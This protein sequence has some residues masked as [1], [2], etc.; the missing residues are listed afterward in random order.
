MS[1]NRT[2]QTTNKNEVGINLTVN[3]AGLGRRCGAEFPENLQGSVLCESRVSISV[4]M[5]LVALFLCAC[6]A[7]SLGGD[8]PF[9]AVASQRAAVGLGKAGVETA[10]AADKSRALNQGSNVRTHQENVDI[11]KA[12]VNKEYSGNSKKSA[13][14][15]QA[16][17]QDWRQTAGDHKSQE[18]AGRRSQAHAASHAADQSAKQRHNANQFVDKN[19]NWAGK[20]GFRK[21]N[22]R[23]EGIS[24]AFDKNF[25]R[26]ANENG[27]FNA[28]SNLADHALD[29]VAVRSTQYGRWVGDHGAGA[30]NADRQSADRNAGWNNA[31]WANRAA[32]DKF[33][34]DADQAAGANGN[35]KD[36]AEKRDSAVNRDIYHENRGGRAFDYLN[37][38]ALLDRNADRKSAGYGAAA[39]V[40]KGYAPAYGYGGPYGYGVAG[41][42]LNRQVY[43]HLPFRRI[44]YGDGYGVAGKGLNRQRGA[45]DRSNVWDAAQLAKNQRWAADGEVDRLKDAALANQWQQD[46]VR[47][48]N[49][50]ERAA[51]RDVGFSRDAAARNEGARA[52]NDQAANARAAHTAGQ[53]RHDLDENANLEANKK[54]RQSDR[55]HK[56]NEYKKF[57]NNDQKGGNNFERLKYNRGT[58]EDAAAADFDVNRDDSS[59][60]RDAHRLDTA[61]AAARS[62]DGARAQSAHRNH[63]AADGNSNRAGAEQQAAS[64][65][66]AGN[67]GWW[68]AEGDRKKYAVE[69]LRRDNNAKNAVA[70]NQ[71]SARAGFDNRAFGK[72]RGAFVGSAAAVYPSYGN[73]GYGYPAAGYG[74]YGNFPQYGGNYGNYGYGYP[75]SGKYGYY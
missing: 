2:A 67:R 20:Q 4:I 41:K 19:Q 17:Q 44:L 70:Q 53:A 64:A 3:S 28:G 51:M 73:Y 49:T 27:G 9:G 52:N 63:H 14:D 43:V 57:F 24:Y 58:T 35:A 39:D 16:H 26:N 29:D 68:G 7:G 6:I 25:R 22:R 33:G 34:R 72:N 45:A 75:A 5:K 11:K 74:G 38:R 31:A 55:D 15:Q 10:K 66:E 21:G 40:K 32:A 8:L 62:R 60:W 36:W 30:H 12:A 46:K 37:D 18:A 71:G 42:G 59:L 23:H 54:W 61:A 65:A 13:E 1:K 48:F 50:D 47:G 56:Y 69:Q